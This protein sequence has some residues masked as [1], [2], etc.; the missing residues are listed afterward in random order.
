M[1]REVASPLGHS[2]FPD[3]LKLGNKDRAIQYL[4]QNDV[5][6]KRKAELDQLR[7]GLNEPFQLINYLQ[8]HTDAPHMCIFPSPE[9][10][11]LSAKDVL[12]KL[13]VSEEAVTDQQNTVLQ[14][15]ND[16]IRD[17]PTKENGK[18]FSGLT[19][20]EHSDH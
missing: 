12:D 2:G 19:Q 8:Q 4:M 7:Q 14:W 20:Q 3:M 15:F 10:V 9:D 13:E 5:I 6:L 11:E 1:D 16:Y 18:C 17:T